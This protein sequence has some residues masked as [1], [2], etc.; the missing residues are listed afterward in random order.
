MRPTRSIFSS[1]EYDPRDF[2]AELRADDPAMYTAVD[3]DTGTPLNFQTHIHRDLLRP[4]TQTAMSRR[5]I[6][7]MNHSEKAGRTWGG[8]LIACSKSE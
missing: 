3:A 7:P 2:S 5:R 8:R 4:K 1:E 6:E